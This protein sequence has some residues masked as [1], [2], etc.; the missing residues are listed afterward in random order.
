MNRPSHKRTSTKMMLANQNVFIKSHKGW[1]TND[2]AFVNILLHKL[3]IGDVR[4]L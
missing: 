3:L 2:V 4:V 1:S